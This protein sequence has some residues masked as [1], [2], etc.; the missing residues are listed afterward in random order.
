MPTF[1][2]HCRNR[3]WFLLFMASAVYLDT[4]KLNIC[5]L[6]RILL[7][8]YSAQRTGTR[9]LEKRNAT[10]GSD[11]HSYNKLK[12]TCKQEAPKWGLKI[13]SLLI[14]SLSFSMVCVGG[15]GVHK[16]P[17]VQMCEGS[18][19]PTHGTQGWNSS[20]QGWWQVPL[21]TEPTHWLSPQY[22]RHWIL[23]FLHWQRLWALS[24]NMNA[25]GIAPSV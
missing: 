19:G 1:T 18:E 14:P 24:G 13:V 10:C 5:M 8:S 15:C 22:F 7:R 4:C 17:N 9:W 6:N 23:Y 16:W 21:A 25:C 12:I 11:L 3:L 2:L 20:C